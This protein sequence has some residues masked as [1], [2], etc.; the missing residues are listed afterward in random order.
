M[1]QEISA[2]SFDRRERVMLVAPPE[3]LPPLPFGN[4]V[5][6]RLRIVIVPHDL[7]HGV[8]RSHVVSELPQLEANAMADP[9]SR[10]LRHSRRLQGEILCDSAG[11]LYEKVGHFVQPIHQL[12]AGPSGEILDLAPRTYRPPVHDVSDDEEQPV[13]DV[14]TQTSRRGSDNPANAG[15]T[16]DA[17]LHTSDWRT[18]SEVRTPILT[19]GEFKTVLAPQLANPTRL[20]D[21]HRLSCRASVYESCRKQRVETLAA[22]VPGCTVGQLLPL[23]AGLAARLGLADLLPQLRT[24]QAQ[25]EPGVVLAGD[26]VVRLEVLNDPTVARVQTYESPPHTGAGTAPVPGSS[27]VRRPSQGT[28]I[29]ERYVLPWQFAL[30]RDEAIYDLNL[31]AT[32]SRLRSWL[33]SLWHAATRRRE[34][35][36]W[37]SLVNGRSLDDQLWAVRPPGDSVSNPAIREWARRMLEAAGYDA[38]AMLFEWDVY[39]RRK[40]A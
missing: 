8:P 33:T 30:S 11:R 40:R 39:W 2:R 29:P 36:K 5:L 32:R 21:T 22:D 25:R 13:I 16:S 10:P 28:T 20:R 1:F 17:D 9:H 35:K 6:H 27:A 4:S 18:L 37:Q 14:P 3:R 34:L 38:S 7:A 12:V 24:P 23:G 19:F 26:R 15:R 31:E